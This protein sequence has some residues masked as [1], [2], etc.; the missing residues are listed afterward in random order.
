MSIIGSYQA[1]HGW[2]VGWVPVSFLVAVI[3]L[4]GKLERV[5]FDIPQAKTEIV[6]GPEVEYTGRRLAP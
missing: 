5:P 3:S 2:L 6:T 4:I 1:T